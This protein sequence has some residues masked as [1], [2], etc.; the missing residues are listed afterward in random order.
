M[1]Y[2]GY[3]GYFTFLKE[4]VMCFGKMMKSIHLMADYQVP[5]WSFFI[6]TCM[7]IEQNFTTLITA[8]ETVIVLKS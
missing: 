8:A 5:G 4:T 7:K 1:L 6:Y 3:Y 2:Y